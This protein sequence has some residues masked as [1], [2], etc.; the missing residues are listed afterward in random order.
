MPNLYTIVSG[1]KA[2]MRFRDLRLGGPWGI[3]I[4]RRPS[5]PIE[6]TFGTRHSLMAA[7]GTFFAGRLTPTG[8][9]AEIPN[10]VVLEVIEGGAT[11]KGAQEDPG[12]TTG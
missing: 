3:L 2:K 10:V 11:L 8:L 5:E 12:R 6:L 9:I 4:E 7:A 1:S